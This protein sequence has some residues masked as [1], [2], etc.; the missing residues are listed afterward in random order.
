VRDLY[1]GVAARGAGDRVVDDGYVD[2]LARRSPVD[3]VVSVRRRTEDLSLRK[4]VADVLE[5][6]EHADFD[7]RG[8]TRYHHSAELTEVERNSAARAPVTSSW[9]CVR[10]RCPGCTGVVHHV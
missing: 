2:E 3:S 9:T 8:T 6:D 10:P 7:P 1:L 4:L 5:G